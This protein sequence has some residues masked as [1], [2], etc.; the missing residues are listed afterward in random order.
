[1]RYNPVVPNDPAIWSL[2]APEFKLFVAVLSFANPDGTGAWPS[3]KTLASMTGVDRRSVQRTITSL[4]ERGIVLRTFEADER[5]TKRTMT[6]AASA[7]AGRNAVIYKCD[8]NVTGDDTNVT[9]SDTN[10]TGGDSGVTGGDKNVTGGVTNLSWEGVT[11][12]SPNHSPIDHSPKPTT[13]TTA[14]VDSGKV[15]GKAVVERSPILKRGFK[16]PATL[17][18]AQKGLAARLL[19]ASGEEAKL[20]EVVTQEQADKPGFLEYCLNG[21]LRSWTAGK[22]SGRPM[23]YLIT[24]ISNSW[25]DGNW[26]SDE[27]IS[28]ARREESSAGINSFMERL[29]KV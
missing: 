23:P 2:P 7:I 19:G 14:A 27:A 29:R 15:S 11:K 24:I 13:T 6:I 5:G 3:N 18:E 10:V 17:S 16:K 26:V 4:I 21:A 8:E 1:M 9:P 12:M 20:C 22:I 25:N 28:Q